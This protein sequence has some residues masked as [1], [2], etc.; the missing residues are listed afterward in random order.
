MWLKSEDAWN[1]P[2]GWGIGV[3][4]W[5]GV[6]G[7]WGLGRFAQNSAF[8]RNAAQLSSLLPSTKLWSTGPNSSH[9]DHEI[10]ISFSVSVIHVVIRQQ[11]RECQN[12]RAP[13]LEFGV[14]FVCSLQK[15]ARFSLTNSGWNR[16]F[17]NMNRNILTKVINFNQNHNKCI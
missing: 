17:I 7:V 16:H 5:G 10:H 4:G 3:G 14:G 2:W 6:G 13:V 1:R 9:S 15:M 11:L 12:W 8:S